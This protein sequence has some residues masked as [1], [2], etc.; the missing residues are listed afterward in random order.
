MYTSQY[1]PQCIPL[2]NVYLNVYL[3]SMYTTHQCNSY[4]NLTSHQIKTDNTVYYKRLGTNRDII[5]YHEIKVC[6]KVQSVHQFHFN[7]KNKHCMNE[8]QN[9]CHIKII[10][11]KLVNKLTKWFPSAWILFLSPISIF[12]IFVD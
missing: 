12:V 4:V 7:D 9:F 8:K 2:I 6:V 10:I 3:S 5:R 1:I 11:Y